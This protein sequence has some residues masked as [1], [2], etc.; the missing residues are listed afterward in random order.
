MG[1]S[2]ANSKAEVCRELFRFH[3][4]RQE[5]ACELL[6]G[7]DKSLFSQ[8]LSGSFG[9]LH[10]IVHHLVWA[11]MVWLG[12]VDSNTV[13]VMQ[14]LDMEGML[15]VWRRCTEKWSQILESSSDEGFEQH[16]PQYYNTKGDAFQNSLAE[17]VFH[18]VDHA[19]YHIGQ[20][21]SAL[22]GLGIEP[23]Q[24]NLIHYLRATA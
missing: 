1:L 24:T 3:R 14:D 12:R 15:D 11:E 6:E 23:V 4:W 16:T 9:S 18:V 17:I 8:Q 22:R 13:A 2:Q 21:M 5:R 7:I 20:L 19:S 10:I